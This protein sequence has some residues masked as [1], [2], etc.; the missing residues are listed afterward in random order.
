MKFA[1]I[2]SV[3]VLLQASK[4]NP[5]TNPLVDPL[6]VPLYATS[7]AQIVYRGVSINFKK[8]AYEVVEVETQQLVG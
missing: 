6:V 1:T 5:L 7:Y 3:T 2:G 8:S 4:V